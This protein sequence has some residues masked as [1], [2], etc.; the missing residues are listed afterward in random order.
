MT[1]DGVGV[2]RVM[3][4]MVAK[5]IREGR[6][7]PLLRAYHSPD[8]TPISALYEPAIR[9]LPRL[10]AFLEFLKPRVTSVPTV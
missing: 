4:V 8:I 5:P 9:R 3:D 10:R 6:L 2:G 7:V 1:L